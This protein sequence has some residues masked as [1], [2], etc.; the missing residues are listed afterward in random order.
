[1]RGEIAARRKQLLKPYTVTAEFSDATGVLRGDAVKA[2]GVTVGRVADFHLRDGIAVVRTEAG[3][4]DD[5]DGVVA[6]VARYQVSGGG[7]HAL[8]ETSRPASRSMSNL[9]WRR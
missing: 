1:M 5:E 8:A 4:P 3:G 2:A 7:S 6:F 9:R